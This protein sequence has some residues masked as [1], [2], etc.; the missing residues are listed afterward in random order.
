MSTIP[1]T[2]D[3]TWTDDVQAAADAAAILRMETVGVDFD[4]LLELAHTAGEVICAHLDRVGPI[5]GVTPGVPPSPLRTAHANVTVELW[6][7]KD[8]P[9]GVLDSWSPDGTATR[10]GSDP[11]QGVY[12]LIKP[13]KAGWGVG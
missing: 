8:A 12:H 11:L 5:P 13:Y 10:I 4:R 7:R 9:F 1:P 3:Q 2:V 6:R